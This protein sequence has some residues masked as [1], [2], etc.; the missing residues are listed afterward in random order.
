MPEC[1]DMTSL[2][3]FCNGK[4]IKANVLVLKM[5]KK[6]HKSGN[7]CCQNLTAASTVKKNGTDVLRE[8]YH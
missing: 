2:F 3:H 1:Q 6:Y 8:I 4:R 7:C 5:K